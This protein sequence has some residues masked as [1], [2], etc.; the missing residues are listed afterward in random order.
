MPQTKW[1]WTL[2]HVLYP[3]VKKYLLPTKQLFEK[4]AVLQIASLPELYKVFERC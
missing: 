4:R 1:H 2:E 3:A